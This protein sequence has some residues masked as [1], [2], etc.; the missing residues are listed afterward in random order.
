MSEPMRR[1]LVVDADATTTEAVRSALPSSDFEVVPANDAAGALEAVREGR[2]DVLMSELLLPDESGLHLLVE[3]RLRFPL[4]PRIVVTALQDFKSTVTAINEAE[5][6][7]FL[8]KPLD[9]TTVRAAVE[10]ALG[11]ASTLHEVRGV[12]EKAERR[13]LALHDLETDFPGI[14]LVSHGPEGY[15]IPPQRLGRVAQRLKGTPLGE[16]LA[17]SIALAESRPSSP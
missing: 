15:F 2:V 16:A 10:E 3:A 5:V 1:V 13:R 14:T 8:P 12:Q 17:A 6:F 7:R 4:V 9:P 11:R